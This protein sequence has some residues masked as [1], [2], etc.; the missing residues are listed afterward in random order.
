MFGVELHAVDAEVVVDESF[1]RVIV[2]VDTGYFASFGQ[3]V[4]DYGVAVALIGDGNRTVGESDRLACAAVAE[5]E[6]FHFAAECGCD[7]FRSHAD[8]LYRDGAEDIFDGLNGLR[9]CERVAGTVGKE[10]CLRVV[11]EDDIRRGSV[12]VDVKVCTAVLQALQNGLPAAEIEHGDLFTAAR[13]VICFLAGDVR[14]EFTCLLHGG[15]LGETNCFVSV[16]GAGKKCRPHDALFPEFDGEHPGVDA[17]NTHE[18]VFLK[19][20]TK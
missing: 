18:S 3:A 16:V 15:V 9:G 5:P 6:L 19:V 20:L 13:Q 1:N 2:E 8:T 7:N 4:A 11:G 17:F 14:D 12:G 10:K